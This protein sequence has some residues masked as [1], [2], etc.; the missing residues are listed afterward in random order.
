MLSTLEGGLK[1]G[2]W[3][4][5]ADKVSRPENLRSAWGRVRSN[6]GAAGVD[7]RSV[8]EFERSAERHLEEVRASLVAGTYRPQAVR[9]V[10]IP[11][12]GR[13]GE[14]RPLGIPTV[15]DRVVQTAVRNVLE[16]I[17]EAGFAEHSYGFRPGRSTKDALRRVRKLINEGHVHVVDADLKSY[18]DTIPHDILLERVRERITDGSVLA[19]VKAFLEANVMENSTEWT[20]EEGTPQGGVISPLLANIYL[21]PLDHLVAGRGWEMVRYADDFVILCRTAGDAETALAVVQEWVAEARL[22]LHPDKTRVVDLDHGGSF[23]FL[24]YRFSK[25]RHGVGDK[26]KQRIRDRIRE[27]TP[28]GATG[29]SMEVLVQR[30][31]AVLRGWFGYYK[32]GRPWTFKDLD[33]FIRGRLR[34]ILWRQNKGRGYPPHSVNIRWKLAYFQKLGLF[35]LQAAHVAERTVRSAV[36]PLTGE[37]CA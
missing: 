13:P 32:H 20:P 31:N 29:N 8:A 16:P 26:A 9:R 1:G 27:L 21:N 2:R 5:L 30:L 34:A 37:P 19:L 6:D 35:S 22:Q 4:A 11:K 24:G 14:T 28:R 7:H 15:R 3:Y 33:G 12:P 36:R 10:R 23:T 18:F 25:G 17:F